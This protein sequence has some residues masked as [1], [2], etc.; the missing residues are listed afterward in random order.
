M[1]GQFC[2]TLALKGYTD[3]LINIFCQQ[4]NLYILSFYFMQEALLSKKDSSP[5]LGMMLAT[6]GETFQV[7]P[8]NFLG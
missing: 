8:K 2:C 7:V 4:G 3:L 6:C 1:G 5:Q